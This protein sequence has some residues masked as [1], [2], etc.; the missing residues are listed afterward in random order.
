M[1]HRRKTTQP[2]EPSISLVERHAPTAID[3]AVFHFLNAHEPLKL[4]SWRQALFH[5]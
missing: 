4:A 5:C 3:G 1:R 2:S